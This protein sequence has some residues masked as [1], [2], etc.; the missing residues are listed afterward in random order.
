MAPNPGNYD[1]PGTIAGDFIVG[2][3]S[4]E[5]YANHAVALAPGGGIFPLPST[6][7]RG[8]ATN[9]LGC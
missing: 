3:R 5:L 2:G 7:G 1:V 8:G 9:S 4:F 6:N